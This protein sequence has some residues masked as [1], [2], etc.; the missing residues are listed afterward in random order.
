[1][2]DE[3]DSDP[4]LSVA[5]GVD[6]RGEGVRVKFKPFDPELARCLQERQAAQKIEGARDQAV[7]LGAGR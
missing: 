7:G 6:Q 3:A 1:M 5:V 2:S 4:G